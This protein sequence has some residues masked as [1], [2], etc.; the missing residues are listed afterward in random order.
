MSEQKHSYTFEDLIE[1]AA[2]VRS[3][4]QGELDRLIIPDAPLD[5]LAQQIVAICSAEEWG[6]DELFTLV[7]GAYPYRELE[8]RD[9][10]D[11]LSM[12]ADGIAWPQEIAMLRI[13][14]D[15]LGLGR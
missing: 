9:F 2:L 11:L 7:R 6:E 10:D 13:I 14:E 15:R 4:H 5:I 8:R 12:L 1:C 3:I